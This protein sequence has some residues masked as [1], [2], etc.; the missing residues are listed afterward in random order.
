MRWYV[1]AMPK[2]PDIK[3]SCSIFTLIPSRKYAVSPYLAASKLK[4]DENHLSKVHLLLPKKQ[5]HKKCTKPDMKLTCTNT[6]YH[7]NYI[8]SKSKCRHEICHTQKFLCVRSVGT[9]GP[10]SVFILLLGMTKSFFLSP[11]HSA[12][13]QQPILDNK[14]WEGLRS[15]E[16]F[17]FFP[18][19]YLSPTILLSQK[20]LLLLSVGTIQDHNILAVALLFI[21]DLIWGP[22]IF[23]AIFLLLMLLC[24]L[25]LPLT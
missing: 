10:R 23:F 20:T 3:C 13:V 4:A 12:T 24:T 9:W 18:H 22:I 21:M 19:F 15:Q 14:V 16:S 1:L 6:H 11:Y 17:I 8:V 25:S 2:W 5:T 7:I